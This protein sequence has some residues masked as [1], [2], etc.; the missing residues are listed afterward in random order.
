LLLTLTLVSI[1]AFVMSWQRHHDLPAISRLAQ[2]TLILVPLGFPFFLLLA[3][4]ER[5]GLGFWSAGGPSVTLAVAAVGIW[6]AVG[7]GVIGS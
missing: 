2:E 6:F 7:T 4:A 1:M 5:L 3:F